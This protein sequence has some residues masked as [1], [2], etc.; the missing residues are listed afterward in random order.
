MSGIRF[1]CLD[2][3]GTLMSEDGPA[4][5]PMA[6]WPSVRVLDGAPELLAALAPSW[7]L[8]IATN[9]I[10]SRKPDIERALERGG[11][12]QFIA[13]VF[14]FTEI[15]SRKDTAEFWRIVTQDLGCA[16]GEVAM[17]GDSLEQDVLGPARHGVHSVWFNARS[18]AVP[19]G[20]T[21]VTRLHDFIRF[22]REA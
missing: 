8:C 9:A 2:W 1:I 11:L 5:L 18:L 20:V 12:R 21:A 17:L 10:V 16:T 4:D 14:C 7:P 19:P 3:G 6:Q 13:H 15:G 22:V